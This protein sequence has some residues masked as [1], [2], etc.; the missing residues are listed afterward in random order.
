MSGETGSASGRR[1]KRRAEEFARLLEESELRIVQARLEREQFENNGSEGSSG[2]TEAVTPGADDQANE[3]TELTV[4]LPQGQKLTLKGIE[5]GTIVEVASWSGKSG[6]HDGAIRML[7]GASGQEEGDE[8]VVDPDRTGG[9]DHPSGALDVVSAE[10]L[11]DTTGVDDVLHPRDSALYSSTRKRNSTRRSARRRNLVK[12]IAIFVGGLL[13]LVGAVIGLRAADILYF[14][15]PDRGL[16]T[17]LG[18]AETSIAAVNPRAGISPDSTVIAEIDGRLVM[19]GVAQ[20]G[21]DELLVFTGASRLVVP[22]ED[23]VG[24]VLFVIPFL[25]YL[26]GEG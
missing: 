2:E 1:E 3:R 12:R 13:L 20:V 6:P 19:V 7:F 8:T 11:T 15:N 21:G 22:K 4:D 9:A 10:G 25:G 26:S 16:T 14:V 17:G 24:R 18:G 23:V 5:P